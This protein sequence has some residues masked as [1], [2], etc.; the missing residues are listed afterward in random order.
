MNSWDYDGVNENILFEQGGRRLLAHF[1]KNGHLFII[2]RTNGRLVY[3]VPF[4][5]TTWGTI[6][7]NTGAM[8]PRLTP[9]AA[10]VE[11]C[12]GPAGGKEWPH[13]SFS[14]ET[15]LLDTRLSMCAPHSR[16]WN[17]S[18]RRASPIG[19]ATRR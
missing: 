8:T 6:D 3:A 5:R 16:G 1:D 11:I 12:P 19:A 2:D 17:P 18:S 7:R 10:G 4:T 14:R 13:A 15:G 9:T